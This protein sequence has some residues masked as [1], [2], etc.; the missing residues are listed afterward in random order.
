MVDARPPI[1]YATAAP[2]RRNKN[3]FLD[4]V[5]DTLADKLLR[6]G[7]DRL[8][9]AF[10]ARCWPVLSEQI[11]EYPLLFGH[12]MPA[13]ARILEFGSNE[14]VLPIQLAALGY[15]VTGVGLA[16]YPFVHR[17]F[18]FVQH[19]ILEWSPPEG[20]FDIAVSLSSVEHVG[21]G[22]GGEAHADGAR[23]DQVAVAKLWRAV[24]PGGQLIL[25]VPAGK[26]CVRRGMRVYD[27]AL[28]RQLVPVEPT[29]LRFFAKA[30]RHGDWQET[31]SEAISRLEYEDY[32][33]A[34]PA[35]GMAFLVAVRP[36]PS[37]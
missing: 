20:Q 37:E 18:S 12:L 15:Q 36:R 21:L 2:Y 3:V 17:N 29:M 28:V 19:D 1:L 24:R 30:G 7:V 27:A 13:P 5:E 4:G 9:A 14:N 16:P 25:S 23:G 22:Y 34:S 6:K 31:T 8:R 11:L 10:G 33:R 35:E 32:E 26:P